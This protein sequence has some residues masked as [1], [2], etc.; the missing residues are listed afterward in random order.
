MFGWMGKILHVN[1]STMKVDQVPTHTYAEKY[2]GGRGIAARIY[3]DTVKPETGAFDPENHLIFMTG[4]LVGTGAQA[5][6]QLSVV[7]KS[8][9]T[10]PEGYCYGSI[11][12][13][14]GAELKK[15][16]FDGIIIEGKANNP[17]YLWIHDGE[18]EIRDAADLRG[19]NGYRTG[20][21][22]QEYHGEKTRYIS[23]GVSGEKLVR[24]A[25]ALAS[26]DCTVSAGFGAVMGSKNLKAIAI[27]GSQKIP[28]ANREK[29]QELNRYTIHISKRMRLTVVPRVMET[30][31]AYLLEA[32]GKGGCH[33]C[34]FECIAATFRYGKR[35]VGHRKCQS[36]EYYLPWAYGRDDE[37]LETFFDAPI[38]CNDF[39]FDSWQMEAVVEWLW[40]CYKG[41]ALTEEETGLPLSKIGTRE[42]L[43]KLLHSIAYREGFGDIL[44][45]G[46]YRARYSP[47]I[48]DKARSF[49]RRNLAPI[50]RSDIFQ[51]RKYVIYSLLYFLEPRI[52]HLNLHEPSFVNGA[53]F[54]NIMEPGSTNI[55]SKVVKD[56]ARAFWGSEAAG[57]F[58]TYE[59]KALAAKIILNRTYLKEILGLCDFAWPILY[60]Y[61][62][63]DRVG[64]PELI[65]NIYE[66]VTGLPKKDLDLYAERLYNLQRMIL[67]REGRK[68]PEADYPFDYNFT[69]P[70]AGKPGEHLLVV[71]PDGE[72]QDMEGNVLDRAKYLDMLKEY[73]RLRGWDEQ[74]GV[75]LPETLKNLGLD[76]LVVPSGELASNTK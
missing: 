26:H 44:A 60:S 22:L 72:P 11:G 32:I 64:D 21:L 20:E 40:D 30:G 55:T 27:L 13:F 74:T 9:M 24:T 69:E 42:F 67:L 1:L 19:Q 41:G 7:G 52:H 53:W 58:S 73:Y 56:V 17:V 57:S 76:D 62:T 37:P 48:S 4:L 23:I 3:W 43:E 14:V 50:G 59:G 34:G 70:L 36:I 18:A 15:A 63:P 49:F 46:P 5:A 61:N 29:L 45:E 28:V 71:G 33:L 6:T 25:N 10:Y 54:F 75:P 66:A 16:G 47:R 65:G 12:G 31:K 39:A 2:L 68:T 8:P 51:P 38:M 35:L